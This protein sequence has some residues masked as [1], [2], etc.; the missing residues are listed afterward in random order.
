MGLPRLPFVLIDQALIDDQATVAPLLREYRASG[1]HVALTWRGLYEISRSHFGKSVAQLLA[2]PNA[3]VIARDTTDLIRDEQKAPAPPALSALVHNHNTDSF[4]RMLVDMAQ[5]GPATTP[6][7]RHALQ[8]IIAQSEPLLK[9]HDDGNVLRNITK[10]LYEHLGKGEVNA[11][12]R[13]LERRDTSSFRQVLRRYCSRKR[14]IYLLPKLGFDMLTAAKAS[15]FPSV[16]MV[17]NV[18][19]YATALRERI[20]QGLEN[21]SDGSLQNEAADV[22]NCTIALFGRDFVIEE[23]KWP[24]LYDDC[25]AV[26]DELW[27]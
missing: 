13:D 12:R 16:A 26:C 23:K 20:R 18:A 8:G 24:V 25:R 9:A 21:R 10:Y 2:E 6:E 14:M 7:I 22:E 11:V 27:P 17:K 1:Q 15:R 4:R 5:R 3:V 19:Y